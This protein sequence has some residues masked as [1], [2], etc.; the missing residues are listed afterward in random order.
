M[1]PPSAAISR[2]M[3]LVLDVVRFAAAGLVLLHHAAFE[4]FGVYLPWR[5]TQTGTEPVMAFFVLSGFVIAFAAETS[6]GTMS[7]FA[8][9]RAA[10]LL[11][12]TIPAL[13]LTVMLDAFGRAIDPAL[14]GDHWGD[15]A[16]LANLAEPLSVQLAATA[17]FANEIWTLHLWPG[18][19][20]PF[21]SLGYEAV[22]YALFAIAYYQRGA[23]P[24]AI[25]LVVA[26]LVVGPKILLLMPVWLMGVGAWRLYKGVTVTPVAG[27]ALCVASLLAYVAFIGDDA[28]DVLDRWTDIWTASLPAG[29]LGFSDHFLSNYASGALF[30][31]GLIG[32]KGLE[33]ALEPLLTRSARVIRAAAACTF[34]MYL[35]HYPL[36]YA[37]RAVAAFV[38]GRQDLAE[39]SWA[40]TAIV[41]LGTGGAIYLLAR[42][43]EQRKSELRLAMATMIAA[44][45][46]SAVA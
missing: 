20:S 35:F 46:R 22:Y 27:A 12:V 1:N 7:E 33:P 42:V 4:K 16:T 21:W 18:T 29:L 37:F 5:L 38:L 8:L 6:D 43:T 11:S 13:V 9:S 15:A 32:L 24:R 39:R 34:S 26:G 36:L 31:G 44:L 3:S 45:R 2:P 23:W 25:G 28:R 10:R 14:Y 40:T 19:N 41:V 17:T 30:T